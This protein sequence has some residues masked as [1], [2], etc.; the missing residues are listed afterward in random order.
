LSKNDFLKNIFRRAISWF[1]F[2]MLTQ[3]IGLANK[4]ESSGKEILALITSKLTACE[5][6][7]A[8]KRTALNAENSKYKSKLQEQQRRVEN[9]KIEHQK[10]RKEQERA[11]LSFQKYKEKT[12]NN[13]A[14]EDKL[15]VQSADKD[16]LADR[17]KQEYNRQV[18]L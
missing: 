16:A 1:L 9:S 11:T 10:R 13:I 4:N 17:S 2:S 5:K 12:E 18:K 14:E 6:R 3:T 7:S 15:R 8:E